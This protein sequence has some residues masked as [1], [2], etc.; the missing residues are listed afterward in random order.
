MDCE[1]GYF[2]LPAGPQLEGMVG[3][4]EKYIYDGYDDVTALPAPTKIHQSQHLALAGH[5]KSPWGEVSSSSS[6]IIF[7]SANLIRVLCRTLNKILVN[8][9]TWRFS[10]PYGV[11]E[12]IFLHLMTDLCPKHSSFLFFSFCNVL[13]FPPALFF[14]L[15][16]KGPY[17][18]KNAKAE[19]K[20]S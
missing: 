5:C 3:S 8:Y 19:W 10:S 12:H 7:R 9:P 16:T 18:W 1:H 13:S 14:T 11:C 15:Y 6:S 20:N 2:L 17:R 4:T